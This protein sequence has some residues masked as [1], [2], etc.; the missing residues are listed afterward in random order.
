MGKIVLFFPL[1]NIF[2]ESQSGL[3]TSTDVIMDGAA[4][5]HPQHEGGV[6]KHA[7]SVIMSAAVPEFT[8]APRPTARDQSA[9]STR[10][11]QKEA[12][13]LQGSEHQ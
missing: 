4:E 7:D 5:L 6:A 11:R 10:Q 12:C 13:H 2:I 9:S 3:I 8:S 1:C